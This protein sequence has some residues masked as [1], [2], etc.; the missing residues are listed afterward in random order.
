SV[1]AGAAATVPSAL[2]LFFRGRPLFLA[3][4]AAVAEGLVASESLFSVFCFLGDGGLA[5]SLSGSALS[6]ASFSVSSS[7]PSPPSASSSSSSSILTTFFGFRL[8]GFGAIS[9]DGA[10]RRLPGRLAA[11]D[12][13]AAFDS[14]VVASLFVA[15]AEAELEDSAATASALDTG[16]VDFCLSAA[17][18]F[19]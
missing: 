1:E 2:T 19:N 6:S 18:C 8:V 3:G 15:A 17:S 9:P 10:R 16:T 14:E 5:S 7:P 4:G 11:A 13:V 12:A